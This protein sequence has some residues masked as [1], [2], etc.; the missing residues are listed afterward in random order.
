MRAQ[1]NVP[2]ISSSSIGTE[3][4]DFVLVGGRQL[5]SKLWEGVAKYLGERLRN[6][7]DP[8][9]QLQ[10]PLISFNQLKVA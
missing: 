3:E 10:L 1:R 6:R 4:V 2:R 9:I 8:A 7:Q 5:L